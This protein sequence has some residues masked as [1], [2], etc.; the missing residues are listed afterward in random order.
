MNADGSGQTRLTNTAASDWDPA[1]SPDGSKIVFVSDRD[2]GKSAIYVMDVN[3]SDQRSLS[4]ADANDW[5][6]VFS[7]DGSKIAF[8]SDRDGNSEIYTMN[9]DGS[10]LAR[11]TNDSSNDLTPD[12]CGKP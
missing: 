9:A 2:G 4:T 7:P 3:A 10:S 6:P 5:S 8:V 11:L 12:W 1:M